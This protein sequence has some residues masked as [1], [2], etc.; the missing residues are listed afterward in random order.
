MCHTFFI[1]FLILRNEAPR[2]TRVYPDLRVEFDDAS[3][4]A[5]LLEVSISFG[6]S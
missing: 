1:G 2:V 3:G 5:I 6:G 4:P